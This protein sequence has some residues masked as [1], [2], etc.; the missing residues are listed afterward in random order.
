MRRANGETTIIY[1]LDGTLIDTAPDL[2][3]AVNHVV[4]TVGGQAV[5]SSRLRPV[6]SYGGRE[7]IRSALAWQDLP[8]DENNVGLLF[9]Q[10]VSYYGANIAVHSRPFPGL[11]DCLGAFATAGNPLGVCTNKLEALTHPLL[12]ALELHAPFATI[13]GRE[14]FPVHK[15]DPRHLLATIARA[16]GNP[17][18]A[19]MIGDSET[20]VKTARAAGI[21]VV[22]VT[23]GYTDVPVTELGC[24]AVISHYNELPAALASL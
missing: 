16:N 13:T 15:P 1:D 2:I 18:N 10:F 21:P 6:V 8:S 3:A 23:F 12:H 17:T 20:D 24:D 5:E 4:A 11:R 19:V 22:G 14:T 7:M 9:D